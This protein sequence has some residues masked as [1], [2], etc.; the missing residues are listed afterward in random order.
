M[1]QSFARP[2]D[3]ITAV[4]T[5][6]IVALTLA[7]GAT[8]V[9]RAQEQQVRSQDEIYEAPA[10]SLS[11]GHADEGRLENPF[12]VVDSD[13]I[14]AVRPNRYGTRELVGL[15]GRA[16]AAV[17]R[18]APGS[19]LAVGDL[20]S[21][22]GGHLTPHESHQSGRDADVG[23]YML[24]E[25]GEPIPRALF[26]RV[27]GDGSARRGDRHFRF[28]DARNWALL[29]AFTDDPMAETQ[30]VI[31]APHLRDRL[32]AYGQSIGASEDQIRRIGLVTQQMRG[33]EGHDD[34]FHV[35]IYC[36]VGDR[37][38][39]LDRPPLHPWYYGTPSPDA[40]AAARVADLQRAAALRRMQEQAQR[41]EEQLQ[42]AEERQAALEAARAR[43]LAREPTRQEQRERARAA[44]LSHDERLALRELQRLEREAE[45]DR[46]RAA[47]SEQGR[48]A[49]LIAEERR[50]RAAERR[51][52]ARLRETQ[53][54]QEADERRRAAALRRQAQRAARLE[55][56]AQAQ[57]DADCRRAQELLRRGE[58]L[59]RERER[60]EMR[61]ERESERLREELR[62]RDGE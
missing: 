31:L 61:R 27:R 46:R 22:T 2:C 10:D 43:E 53:R 32:I 19:R 34:H 58:R 49:S 6:P 3:M 29:V 45:A 52:A 40:V 5:R 56:R 4:R 37:P 38:Q 47:A 12:A 59:R 13:V 54:R 51:R 16:A 57:Q 44:R 24:D 62:H 39:C 14:D 26:V 25:R 28:D 7:L 8:S 50:W 20:S 23:Y 33:S 41:A 11:I 15:L 48:A 1:K 36:S 9:A 35:R 30:Y 42:R 60:A 18:S 21:E 17:A 55:M